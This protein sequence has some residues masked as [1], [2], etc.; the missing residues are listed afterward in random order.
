MHIHT[1]VF[2]AI[3]PFPGEH[4]IDFSALGRSGLFLLEGPT[5]SGKS[6][7]IDAIVFALYGNVASDSASKDRLHSDHAAPNVEPFVEVT[8]ET[9]RGLFRVRRT[10]AYE[11]PKKRGSGTRMEQ[12]T[13]KLWRLRPEDID[14]GD[15]G[16]P[17]LMSNR[18]GEADAELRDLVGLDR[19]QF[20]QTVVLPQGEFARFLRLGT[21]ERTDVL[22]RLFGTEI[23][24]RITEQ[25]ETRRREVKRAVE[26]AQDAM[27]TAVE[28][29]IAATEIDQLSEAMGETTQ[30][31]QL[32]DS[33]RTLD[34]EALRRN[35]DTVVGV[36]DALVTT[37]RSDAES[38]RAE[39]QHAQDAHQLVTAAQRAHER[40]SDAL[41]R[42]AALLAQA[43]KIDEQQRSVETTHRVA[44]V[45]SQLAAC[46]SD[47]AV[48]R[49][50][51][52]EFR[53]ALAASEPA[54]AAAGSGLEKPRPD[55]EESELS[56]KKPDLGSEDETLAK[57]SRDLHEGALRTLGTIEPLLE[58]EGTRERL[59][60]TIAEHRE[61]LDE[62]EATSAQIAAQL[63]TRPEGRA[64]IAARC[65]EALAT[66][67][68]LPEITVAVDQLVRQHDA[69]VERDR[70]RG[71]LTIV[72][73][74]TPLRMAAAQ[75]AIEQERETRLEW[76]RTIAGR[77]ATH[78]VV[79]QPCPVCGSTS[80][81]QPAGAEHDTV[82]DAA[83]AAAERQRHEHETALRE[84]AA[85]ATRLR[86]RLEETDH[87]AGGDP[88]AVVARELTT[89]REALVA[90]EL[91]RDEANSLTDT[92]THWDAETH[93]LEQAN[94]TVVAS[95]E[96][97][98]VIIEQLA[99]R[100]KSLD[101][102]LM[103]A[104]AGF[105]SIAE[106]VAALR[107]QSEQMDE[108]EHRWQAVQRARH[109]AEASRRRLAD[110]VAQAG[111]ESPNQARELSL[112]DEA[113][114]VAQE[115]IQRYLV[116]KVAVERELLEPELNMPDIVALDDDLDAIA[117]M[118]EREAQARALAATAALRAQETHATVRSAE[119]R[120]ER[121]CSRRV[122][123]DQA[124]TQ[125]EAVITSAA[126]VIRMANLATGL[127][128][129]G[130]A[131]NSAVALHTF[132]LMK[133]FDE[134]V[135]AANDRLSV[136]SDGRY[137]LERIDTKESGQRQRRSGL[138]LRVV[139][140]V[141]EKSRDPKTLSGG[142]TF[143]VS[144]CL[145]LGMADVVVAESGGVDLGTL[146]V[147]EG[148]GTLDA[149]TLDL[150]LS[151]LAK[152]RHGGRDVGVVSH[153]DE[154]K[155]RISERV[156]LI[157]KSDGSSTLTVQV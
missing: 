54:M 16:D 157:R 112:S 36:L 49:A 121:A 113:L 80:H 28:A 7:I 101:E 94:A 148:F 41:M 145:A 61:T 29:F 132:V 97:V 92:L 33:A 117:L 1:L 15:A 3:G 155:T 96:R 122:L 75:Q 98:R 120:Y 136:M 22:Q 130:S 34:D 55:F 106:R 93:S 37:A 89:R 27:S 50:A 133:R 83:L 32:R 71:E 59:D 147:D 35:L 11:R 66:A 149:E 123:I 57:R 111:V 53:S 95:A 141:T 134:V 42:R 6:T 31:E 40:R 86:E 72:D 25:L 23:Y 73:E 135:A 60:Q 109:S 62:H 45:L 127:A 110:A 142:E 91:A 39:L 115:S 51:E 58:L 104:R 126:P 70:I 46:E 114:T 87:Q 119:A 118:R 19:N 108:I 140:H 4:L 18:L 63:A 116:D 131:S 152:L 150:V 85:V 129:D 65:E 67:R 69:S 14:G 153:V 52:R 24:E 143:Y 128:A 68:N 74:H 81:P 103:K 8:F 10:P 5:G 17:V 43:E 138:G 9:A 125:C 21:Q 139:D 47:G 124:R 38:A 156:H 13:V 154:L 82:S 2:G 79:D 84:H 20:V 102:Q 44:R 146:F 151:Q 77:L 26:T 64:A 90:A 12:P 100:V 30:A 56:R 144:L 105:T 99:E 76:T 107:R 88:T 78:L 137:E 48:V